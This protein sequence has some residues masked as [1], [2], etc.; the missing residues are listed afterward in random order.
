MK[1]NLRMKMLHSKV[2][3]KSTKFMSI[4]GKS[5]GETSS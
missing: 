3:I 1:E 4:Y 5:T 2:N